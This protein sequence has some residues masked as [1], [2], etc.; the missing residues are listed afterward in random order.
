MILG[1]NSGYVA[2]QPRPVQCFDLNLNHE[3]SASLIRPPNFYQAL[4]VEALYVLAVL[5]MDRNALASS[6]ESC[7][8]VARHRRAAPG[9]L[10]HNI[11]IALY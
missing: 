11:R 8:L 1:K 2:E 9:H 3:H 10:G 6:D 7:D 5:S 4:L